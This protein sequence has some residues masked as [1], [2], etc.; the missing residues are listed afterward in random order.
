MRHPDLKSL[1]WGRHLLH[2]L[3]VF[4]VDPHGPEP[5]PRV[6]QPMPFWFR[7][8]AALLTLLGM[9]G[10]IRLVDG[11]IRAAGQ[12]ATVEPGQP[13]DF[14]PS[15]MDPAAWSRWTSRLGVQTAVVLPADPAEAG[16]LGGGDSL[17]ATPAVAVPAVARSGRETARG[18][19]E[20]R[21]Q[22]IQVT[23]YTSR[24][25]ETDSTPTV[26]ASNTTPAA[27][28]IALSRDLLRTFT[29]NAPFGF[30][31]KV[32]IPGVG[33]FDVRDTMHPRWTRKADIWVSTRE[34]ARAWGRRT[35]FIT[36][37][38]RDAPT[39]AHRVARLVG[40]GDR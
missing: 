12:A 19:R 32:L 18:A 33:I 11:F 14:D 21:F 22:L 13:T 30:G 35:V 15:A 24:V 17:V 28:T 1:I 34:Q 20:H 8:V 27:G 25:A 36:R 38:N 29:P 4:G 3:G 39:I 10:A 26:T 6:A 9:F 5:A 40:H 31:D 7:R 16:R 2:L 37:V 23:A